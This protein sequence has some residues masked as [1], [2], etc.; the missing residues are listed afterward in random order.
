MFFLALWYSESYDYDRLS[1][2]HGK[3]R[4]SAS[5]DCIVVAVKETNIGRERKTSQKAKLA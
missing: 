2:N 4:I 3:E 5:H 1:F